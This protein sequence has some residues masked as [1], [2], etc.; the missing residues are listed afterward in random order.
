MRESGNPVQEQSGQQVLTMLCGTPMEIGCFLHLAVGI[1]LALAAEHKRNTIYKSLRPRNILIEPVTKAVKLRDLDSGSMQMKKPRDAETMHKFDTSIA[2]ASPEQL[3]RPNRIVDSR[4]D[5]YSLGVI[6]YKMLTGELPFQADDLLGWVHCHFARMPKPPIQIIPTL[7]PII[8]DIVMKLM[9]KTVEDRYQTAVGLKYDLVRCLTC[10]ETGRELERFVLGERDISDQL[11][12]P[13]KLYGREKDIDALLDAFHRV[14][15]R[16]H[17]ELMLI[18]G[19]SGTGKTS[20]VRELYRPVVSEHGLFISGKFDQYNRDI[21]YSTIIEAFQGL[22]RQILSEQEER[23]AVWREQI[24]QALGVNGRVIVD[25]IPQLEFIIGKQPPAAQLPRADAENRLKMVFRRFIGIFSRKEHPLVVFLDDLQWAD[26]ASLKLIEHIITDKDIR[27]LFLIGTYRDN[28]VDHPLMMAI[29]K[30]RNTPAIIQTVNLSPLSFNDVNGLITD[31]LHAEKDVVEPLS[32]LI[33]EKTAGNPFFVTQ[34][35]TTLHREH[36]IDFDSDANCW[37]W[38][39]GRTQ[40]KDY[41]DNVVE[42]M[43]AKFKKLS[44]ESQETLKL[45]ACIGST[46]DLHHL[47][48]V[49][50]TPIEAIK[51]GLKEAID[52][53]LLLFPQDNQCSFMH[54][55]VRQ[56]AYSSIPAELRMEVHLRIGRLL[57]EQTEPDMLDEKLFEIVNHFNLG[58]IL[59]QSRDERCRVSE[60]DLRAGKKAKASTAYVSASTYFSAGARLLDETTWKSQYDLVFNLYRELAETEYLNGNFAHSKELID[61]LLSKA[62]SDIERAELYNILIIQYTLMAQYG[63]AI[64]V[65]RKALHLLN[66]SIPQGNLEEELYREIEKY[67]GILGKRKITSLLDAPEMSDPVKRV[68]LELLSNVLV[69]ARYTESTLFALIATMSANISLQFGPTPKSTVGYTAFGM[70]LHSVMS[71]YRDAYEFGVL[72]LKISERF[73]DLAQKCQAC[74]VLGHYLTHWVRHLKCADEILNNGII[75]GQAAGE[76]QWTGYTFAYKTFG[77]FY[78]GVHLGS[79]KKEIPDLLSYTRKTRNRWATDTLM[80]LQIA[81]SDLEGDTAVSGFE[82]R[83]LEECRANKSFGALGRY[84][85]LKAQI[86]Y[87]YGRMEEA[88]EAVSKALELESFFSSSISVSELN[89]Y[90]SLVSAGLYDDSSQEKREECLAI[91]RANQEKMKEWV[92]NCEENFKHQYL[93]VQ[94]EYARIGDDQIQAGLLYEQSVQLARKQGFVQDEGIACELASRFY[95]QRGLDTI[96]IAYLKEACSCYARWGAYGKVR[97]LEQLDPRLLPEKEATAAFSEQIGHLDAMAVIKALQ[98]ISGEI[99]FP[100]LL[101]ALMQTVIENAGAQKGCLIL[102]HDN[103]LEIKA[104]ARVEGQKIKVLQSGPIDPDSALPVSVLNYVRRTG[105]TVIVDDAT[106][107]DIISSDPYIQKC[108]PLSMLCLPLLRQS[109]VVGMLYLEHSLIKR[110][111][112][113]DRVAVLEL[114]AAQAAIS[115]ENAVLYLERSKAEQALRESEEKYRAIFEDSGTPLIFIEEDKTISICNKAFEK[116]SGYSKAEIEGRKKWTDTVAE[117]DD[118]SRMIEYHRLRRIDPQ[119]VPQTY[120]FRL[121]DRQGRVKDIVTT[122]STMPGGRQS[123]AGLLDVTERNRAVEELHRSERKFRAIFDRSVQFMGLMTTD[124]RILEVNKTALDFAAVADS[125]IRGK[126]FWQTPWWSHSPTLRNRLK[127]AVKKAAKGEWVQFEATHPAVDGS[128]HYIDFSIKPVWDDAGKVILLI[129]EGRDI[130]ERKRAEEENARLATA[131]EQSAE[132]IFITDTNFIIR[133]LNPAFERMSGYTR[134]EVVGRHTRILETGTNE[135]YLV[136]MD[137][138]VTGG[139][140]S[141]RLLYKRKDNSIYEAEMTASPVRDRSGKIIN[142]VTIHRDITREVKLEKELRQAHKMEAIGTL[143]GGIAHDFNNIL[144]AIQ[145]HTQLAHLKLSAKSP[146]AYSL[147]QVL[148]SCSRAKDLVQQILAFSRQT[149][150]EKK[151]VQLVSVVN[152]VLTL[153][154]SSLPTTIEIRRGIELKPEQSVIL[155]DSTQI[156]QVVMNLS[157]NA[158][159]AIGTGGGV[160]GIGL[161]QA[162]ID[163]SMVSQYPDLHFGSYLRLTVEDTGCGVDPAIIERIFDP[164][165]TT[166]L[167]GQGT[168]MGLA[169]TQGIVKAHKGAITVS[170]EPGV[171]TT[172]S[173]YFPELA[174]DVEY[175]QEK[176]HPLLTGCERILFIDDEEILVAL[177]KEML[178]ILGY[179]VTA[180]TRS[181]DALEAFL[182]KPD[183]F[184]LVISDMTMPGLTGIELAQKMLAVRADLPIIICTGF[185]ELQSDK[186]SQAAGIREVIRKPYVMTEMASIIRKVLSREITSPGQ[187]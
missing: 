35:V 136:I 150:H 99:V 49:G 186:Q 76:M 163:E 176:S 17:S 167:P 22:I 48:I 41:T 74:L 179:Q 29:E 156:H 144:T 83:Y 162:K 98:A 147:E 89:F 19:Y 73:N 14:T 90:S 66:V 7:P 13:E 116:I 139:T 148:T 30:I 77:P 183:A 43:T 184:D 124:G 111:F 152:E 100:R 91:I 40:A 135:P 133:Y 125:A 185:S 155:A 164:Y 143:A 153:L 149:E 178:E 168:G 60:L 123:L 71:N 46:F 101:E 61:L 117:P 9:T 64:E 102:V 80:G 122:V 75:D 169:V 166:K 93:L 52:E 118:L 145:G 105:D 15:T 68:S 177:G 58:A 94:A 97:Q 110:A 138:L 142:Y 171:G 119:S 82:E 121:L 107:Q 16:G 54:D 33:Y 140:W 28:E 39:V 2:Y 8:S 161:S 120:E 6:F 130:T 181:M 31:T 67:R 114:L 12:I 34:F 174:E 20:L 113:R 57:L 127:I 95:R 78:R 96:A 25:I 108:R 132:A 56:A 165:F 18:A 159:H 172:F 32:R 146:I 104:E 84:A 81:L 134:D 85:V 47:A 63:K 36:L 79:I 26:S 187:A 158:A 106:V 86:H 103:E 109:D 59:L 27:Y 62:R 53:A 128:L 45:A 182:D 55:R 126:F 72:A 50:N 42:L 24:R 3:G 157:T 160:L 21:P 65:G 37:K 38:D 23:L 180:T 170:S 154:R 44:F 131:I 129:P 5:L 141:G 1:T 87:L 151:P 70:V 11:L 137:T 51:E 88:V 69:T 173:V 10:Y 92:N 115:L 112:T 4:S 175:V